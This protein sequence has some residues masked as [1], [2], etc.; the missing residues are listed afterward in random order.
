LKTCYEDFNK[1]QLR[2]TS[3]NQQSIEERKDNIDNQNVNTSNNSSLNEMNL[4]RQQSQ[5]LASTSSVNVSNMDC[6]KTKK[7]QT[8]TRKL[9]ELSLEMLMKSQ[10]PSVQYIA[11][12]TINRIFD[13]YVYHELFYPGHYESCYVPTTKRVVNQQSKSDSFD[14]F[15]YDILNQQQQQQQ[16]AKTSNNLSMTANEPSSDVT[17]SNTNR[18]QSNESLKKLNK[19][20]LNNK[21][22]D[23]DDCKIQKQQS[24]TKMFKLSKLIN[25]NKYCNCQTSHIVNNTSMANAGQPHNLSYFKMKERNSTINEDPASQEDKSQDINLEDEHKPVSTLTRN[26]SNENDSNKRVNSQVKTVTLVERPV[27]HATLSKNPSFSTSSG[28]KT[29]TNRLSGF[30]RKFSFSTSMASNNSIS[31]ANSSISNFLMQDEHHLQSSLKKSTYMA[32]NSADGLI[33]SNCNKKLKPIKLDKNRK[34][35]NM[36]SLLQMKLKESINE[37]DDELKENDLQE[38]QKDFTSSVLLGTI[39][40]GN[41]DAVSCGLLT[42]NNPSTSKSE[43]NPSSITVGSANTSTSR[44]K[45]A[46]NEP[47]FDENEHQQFNKITSEFLNKQKQYKTKNEQTLKYSFKLKSNDKTTTANQ[48]RINNLTSKFDSN[49][50]QNDMNANDMINSNYQNQPFKCL[51]NCIEPKQLLAIILERLES[52]KNVDINATTML[53][54]S[55]NPNSATAQTNLNQS[56]TTTNH[57]LNKVKCMPSARTINCQHHCVAILSARVFAILCNEM[58]FQQRLMGEHQEACFNMII[59]ILYPNNDPVNFF[60]YYL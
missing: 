20:A 10:V 49:K 42:L 32:N 38:K 15:Q 31:S 51:A 5:P 27:L 1:R 50:L 11:L 16:D 29:L 53:S 56:T 58:A 2:L 47:S 37:E 22:N 54:S 13:I 48:S 25:N 23:G 24:S 7:F 30:L 28:F 6:I 4:D 39:L 19:K 59:D 12:T 45:L 18:K 33:C 41:E 46:P 35:Q 44:S 34:L 55:S 8:H 57:I 60:L 17:K 52:H 43:E 21:N 3:S 36:S 26:D 14:L 40:N 9:I